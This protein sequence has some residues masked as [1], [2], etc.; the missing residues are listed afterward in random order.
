MVF[1]AG[2]ASGD[3]FSNILESIVGLIWIDVYF[4]VLESLPSCLFWCS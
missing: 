2:L 4:T 1:W 3:G